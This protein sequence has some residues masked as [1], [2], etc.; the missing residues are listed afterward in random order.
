MSKEIGRR[1]MGKGRYTGTLE[2]YLLD[3]SAV[4]LVTGCRVWLLS[5]AGGQKK[6]GVGY[7][8]FFWSQTGKWT[9]AHRAAHEVWVGPIPEGLFVL[10]S[11]NNTL[12]IEPAHLYAGTP[13]RNMQDMVQSGRDNFWGW[14]TR[15]GI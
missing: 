8:Y 11:C 12:C 7:G 13:L 14:R 5:T 6:D 3:R 4:D 9:Y 10:H 1:F 15:H 2:Q